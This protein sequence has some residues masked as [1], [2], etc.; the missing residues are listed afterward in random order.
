MLTHDIDIGIPV[1][2]RNDSTY[3]I[4]SSP[5]G[6]PIIEVFPALSLQNSDGVTTYGYG[7]AEYMQGIQISRFL[8]IICLVRTFD[9]KNFT[10]N[11]SRV[12]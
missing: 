11:C 2:Y 8:I 4:L 9:R 12:M 3:H 6:S 7:A 5:Y 1:L 10:S